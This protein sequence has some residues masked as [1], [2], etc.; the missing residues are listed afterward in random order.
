MHTANNRQWEV[1]SKANMV[2]R[3]QNDVNEYEWR[4]SILVNDV[5][6]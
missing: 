3:I 1:V 4:K 6:R 2:S 5:Q